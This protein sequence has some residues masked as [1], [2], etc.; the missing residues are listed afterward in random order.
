MKKTLKQRF[1]EKVDK[2]AGANECWTWTGSRS[3]DG[4][5]KI[6][7]KIDNKWI[8]IRVHRLSYKIANG[9]VPGNKFVCHDCKPNPDNILC[10]NPKHLW[11]GTNSENLLDASKK[12]TIARGNRHG[13]HTHPEKVIKGNLHWSRLF[14]EKVARGNRHGTHIHPETVRKGDRHPLKIHPE[15][16]LRGENHPRTKFPD[17]VIDKMRQEYI[18]YKV[19][20]I[21]LA[22]K[23]G[24]SSGHVHKI[25][26]LQNRITANN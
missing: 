11:L 8:C 20:T 3:P 1:W 26:S 7:A 18:P 17:S 14:P 4:Y 5:G 12:G 19:S 21:F 24:M 15:L 9:F 22:K 23:Y 13:T 6:G 16:A 2:S 10:V 25:V